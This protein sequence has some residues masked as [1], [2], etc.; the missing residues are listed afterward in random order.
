M[1]DQPNLLLVDD[2]KSLLRLLSMRLESEGFRVT[3]VSDGAA[4]LQALAVD[5]YAVAL[6][7]IRMP[8]MDGLQLFD[9]I[10]HLHPGMPVLLIT[11][12]GSI[13]EAVAATQRGVTGFLTKPLDHRELR[14][15]LDQAL[16]ETQANG[17][18]DWR[19]D[20]I[21]RSPEME[22]LLD[23]ARQIAR[24]DVSVLITGPSGTG[25]EMI[26]RAIH[27]ASSRADGP[28]IALNCGALPEHLLESELFGHARGAFTGAVRER[29][30]LFREADRGTLFLD[31]IGDMPRPLQVKLLRVLQEHRVR[32][33]GSNQEVPMDVRVLSATH[34]DL[35]AAM[36]DRAFR[37][38]LYYRLNVVSLA[39]PPL[40]ERPEDIPLLVRHFLEQARER[41]GV[42]V[43]GFARD[44]MQLLSTAPW[45]GNV[46]QLVNVVEQCVALSPGPRIPAA[47]VR[48]ALAE[49]AAHWPTL[50][51]ARNTFECQ[52][53]V[54]VLRMADGNVTRAADLAGRNRTDFY[55]LMHKHGIDHSAATTQDDYA[56]REASKYTSA[57]ADQACGRQASR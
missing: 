5:T 20:I 52:Y 2:D 29:L 48:Q 21:T 46:R 41:S 23:Q 32:P 51:D 35:Q 54:R 19:A 9:Q 12:H 8:G 53:L 17:R 27:R 7:D 18:N 6:S 43:T 30:G 13:Q 31:E 24:S 55:K 15:Q 1:S 57:A 26:A 22:R 3:A 11:A 39:L 44:A 42:A 40:R 50:T 47:L 36:A 16:Q 49:P 38:D 28:F 4:A 25:K 34:Q 56:S 45:P 14:Y 37:E 33:L 10:T